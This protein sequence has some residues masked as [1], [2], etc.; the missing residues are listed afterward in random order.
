ME[1]VVGRRYSRGRKGAEEGTVPRIY[2]RR[3][4]GVIGSRGQRVKGCRGRD[5]T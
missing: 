1:G 4:E 5:S 2:C 3:R